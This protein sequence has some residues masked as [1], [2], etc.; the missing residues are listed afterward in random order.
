MNLYRE[1]RHLSNARFRKRILTSV[2]QLTVLPCA[3]PLKNC[4]GAPGRSSNCTRLRDT[5]IMRL[6]NNCNAPSETRNHSSIKR[7]RRCGNFCFRRGES[8]ECPE[9]KSLQALFIKRVIPTNVTTPSNDTMWLRG[10]QPNNS[11]KHLDQPIFPKTLE[12]PLE[13]GSHLYRAGR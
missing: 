11:V 5:R 10:W 1:T 13:R 8:P 9:V 6:P 12:Q 7:R 2:E 3:A 4:Q